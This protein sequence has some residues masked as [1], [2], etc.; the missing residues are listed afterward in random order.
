MN[1]TQILSKGSIRIK[2]YDYRNRDC[3]YFAVDEYYVALHDVGF[4][5][6]EEYSTVRGYNEE[7]YNER[8]H[9]DNDE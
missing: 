3:G 9:E 2:N 5:T 6:E 7:F 8:R 4:I 1:K